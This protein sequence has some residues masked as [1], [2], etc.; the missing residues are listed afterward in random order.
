M[1]RRIPEFWGNFKA[2]F[3]KG[4][5]NCNGPEI[6]HTT[7]CS[8]SIVVH[9]VTG[10]DSILSI[11]YDNPLP[12]VDKHLSTESSCLRSPSTAEEGFQLP[13]E[14]IRL[15]LHEEPA[16]LFPFATT[17]GGDFRFNAAYQFIRSDDGG[18]LIIDDQE[19]QF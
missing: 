16:V 5:E 17:E 14:D 4:H 10:D 3:E 2:S 19:L 15:F 13:F 6:F 18:G 12:I 7:Q 1:P 9:P 11:S 8:A